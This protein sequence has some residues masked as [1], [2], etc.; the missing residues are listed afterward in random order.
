MNPEMLMSTSRTYS[1]SHVPT[2][3][4]CMVLLFGQFDK[5]SNELTHSL[6]T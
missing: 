6:N 5:E 4:H 1:L 2:V 3:R